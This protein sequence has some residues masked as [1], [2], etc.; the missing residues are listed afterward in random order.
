MRLLIVED[1]DIVLKIIED[2]VQ[3]IVPKYY[4]HLDYDVARCFI[5]AENIIKKSSKRPYDVILLDHRMPLLYE[6]EIEQDIFD[7]DRHDQ[8]LINAGYA[9]I[10]LIRKVNPKT[11]I[12]GTSS[13]SSEVEFL[14]KPD[15]T[16]RKLP[17]TIRGDLDNIL[18][19]IYAK[20]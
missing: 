20:K 19:D 6:P 5:D 8:R 16:L 15:Y 13:L 12:I 7:M 14:A 9:L 3:D 10:P 2:A 18:Q 4:P 11:V 17:D 1:I